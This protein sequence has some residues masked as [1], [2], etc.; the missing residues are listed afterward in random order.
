MSGEDPLSTQEI[1]GEGQEQVF[2]SLGTKP[3]VLGSIL[4]CNHGPERDGEPTPTP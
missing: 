1:P 2:A 4:N 3:K